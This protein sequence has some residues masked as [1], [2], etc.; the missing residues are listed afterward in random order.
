M[1]KRSFINYILRELGFYHPSTIHHGGKV[2]LRAPMLLPRGWRCGGH[3]GR[4]EPRPVDHGPCKGHPSSLNAY[5]ALQDFNP[6]RGVTQLLHQAKIAAWQ[7]LCRPQ[8]D[9]KVFHGRLCHPVQLHQLLHLIAEEGRLLGG[10]KL[11][12][13]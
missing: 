4:L 7:W 3:L 11:C 5:G 12:P 13:E 1:T 8:L 9:A 10:F 2:L 6:S